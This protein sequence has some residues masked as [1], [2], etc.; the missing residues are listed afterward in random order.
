MLRTIPL[1][2]GAG[3]V[4]MGLAGPS[5]AQDRVLR[6]N[7]APIGEL[8]PHKGKD[9]ADSMLM[10]NV[11]DFLVRASA[12][13]EMVPDLAESWAVS[14][15]GLTYT[16]KLR[17]AVFHDG[18]PIEAQDVIYSADRIATLKRGFSYLLPEFE[19]V[20]ADGPKTV[21]FR[22]KE[23]SAP[24]V[25]A[26]T[27]LAVVNSD[28][29]AANYKEGDFGEKGDYGDQF[30]SAS[31]AAS[32]SY[33]VESHNPQE[34]TVLRRNEGH[35]GGFAEN[36]PDVVR[37][38]YA[39]EPTT[40][41]ALMP[42]GEHDVTRMQLPVE[43]LQAL[44]KDPNIS[45]ARDLGGAAFYIKL[46]MQRPPTDDVHFRKAIALAFDYETMYTLLQV[47][48][49]VSAGAPANGPV[50]RGVVGFS[51]DNAYPARDLEAAKAEL[52]K[53]KYGPDEHPFVIQWV[54][55]VP[56]YG[57]IALIFQQSMADIGIDVEVVRSPWALLLEKASKAETTPNANTVKV[58]SNTPDPDSLL[59][60][61]YHS[62][63]A[64]SWQSMDWMLD[65]EIDAA[66]E[67]GRTILDPARRKA[68]YE[69]LVRTVI[70]LQP[71]IFA[72]ET[73]TVVAKRDNVTAPA[74]E[75]PNKAIVSTGMNY[76][77][78]TF[79]IN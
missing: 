36:A 21:V 43:I 12:D 48:D 40:L 76:L 22:L 25:A 42:R 20:T 57:D 52:A 23:P 28:V 70:D 4:A 8:D 79:S 61:M 54:A 44:D 46:N 38:N 78:R 75:D 15:D 62:S 50:P 51:A 53:S 30:L 6:V 60:S 13:G 16:F 69:A 18:S 49:D 63:N 58:G 24:F 31:T 26:L 35:Y 41:R 2:L 77:F 45:L 29:V 47:T 10:F 55:E 33:T 34:L 11:Y 5:A 66:L 32:G 3:A 72:Y 56:S 17:D 59:S 9:Y 68:H 39:L 73:L 19:S 7:D 37:L 27:R 65:P 67:E 1:L 14:D 71:S 74:L 64:G